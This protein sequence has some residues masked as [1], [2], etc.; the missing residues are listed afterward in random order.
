MKLYKLSIESTYDK[1]IRF[2]VALDKAKALTKYSELECVGNYTDVTIEFVCDRSKIIP[3]IEP[4]K[5]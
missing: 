3:T 5:E 2:I 4:I 1:R